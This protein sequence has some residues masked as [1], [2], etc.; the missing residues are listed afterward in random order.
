MKDIFAFKDGVVWKTFGQTYEAKDFLKSQGGKWNAADK[1]WEWYDNDLPPAL[2]RR[3]TVLVDAA[4]LPDIAK[5][6]R[7]SGNAIANGLTGEPQIITKEV[8]IEVEKIVEK[9][10]PVNFARYSRSNHMTKKRT[11]AHKTILSRIEVEPKHK[12]VK[13]S[14]WSEL[15]DYL[16]PGAARPVV[17]LVGPA[18]NGKT[19]V[20]KA[21]M[22]AYE[23]QYIEIDC[24]EFTEPADLIGGMMIKAEKGGTSSIWIDGPITRAFKEGLGIILNEYDAL[25]P[26]AALC[27]QSVFQDAGADK[28][29]RYVTT[30]GCPDHDRVYPQGDCPIILSL[31]TYGTGG[32]RQY[33]GRNTM[34]AAS[35]DRITLITTGYENEA[36]IIVAHGYSKTVGEKL[37]KWANDVRSVIEGNTLKVIL[38]NR[39]LIRMAQSLE[40]YG[41]SW[42]KTV[43]KE[44]LGRFESAYKSVLERQAYIEPIIRE[45]RVKPSDNPFK[46]GDPVV[47]GGSIKYTDDG[48]AAQKVAAKKRADIRQKIEQKSAEKAARNNPFDQPHAPAPVEPDQADPPKSLP[49]IGLDMNGLDDMKKLADKAAQK[50]GPKS[51][52]KLSEPKPE[53]EPTPEPVSGNSLNF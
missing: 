47:P 31:N 49:S 44:F 39:T 14:Y 36:A 24:T 35:M 12:M 10:V 4:N 6:I 18:G 26:R 1:T 17:G 42:R 52:F 38:S 30:V 46:P 28:K 33:V 27:L 15:A 22:E 50:L 20:A 53:T 23:F 34:D 9:R 7:D 13:P 51:R 32:S 25:N 19:T 11:K 2:S 16:R 37:E 43:E 48:V 21:A 41:W 45:R 29:G 5:A 3:V 8:E 40:V